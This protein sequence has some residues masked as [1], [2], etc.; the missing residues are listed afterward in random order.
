MPGD[1]YKQDYSLKPVNLFQDETTH[2]C[3]PPVEGK[4]SCTVFRFAEMFVV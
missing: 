2:P 1:N 4:C 3:T